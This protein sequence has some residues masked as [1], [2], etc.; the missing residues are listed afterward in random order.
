ML[1]RPSETLMPPH[2]PMQCALP[3][4]PVAKAVK[5]TALFI[6]FCGRVAGAL[7]RC[8]PKA[9]HAGRFKIVKLAGAYRPMEGKYG[10]SDEDDRDGDEQKKD[11]HGAE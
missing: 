11:L 2:M 10:G 8:R 5:I 9:D 3:A 6:R 1:P 7:L 4:R